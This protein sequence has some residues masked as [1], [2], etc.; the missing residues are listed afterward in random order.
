MKLTGAAASYRKSVGPNNNFTDETDWTP[1]RVTGHLEIAAWPRTGHSEVPMS[2]SDLW[3]GLDPAARAHLETRDYARPG[4]AERLAT[5]GAEAAELAGGPTEALGAVWIPGVEIF[6]RQVWQ[7]RHRGWFAEFSRRDDPNSVLT[8]IGMWPAQWATAL[9][10]PNTAKGFHIHPPHVPTGTAAEAWF[11]RLFLDQ[12]TNY[13]LRPYTLE[14]WDAMFFVH[15]TC[16]MVLVEA[17]LG[18][19]RRTMRFV[20]EGD[21]RPGASNVGVVIPPGVAHAIR[22]A[23]SQDLIMVYGT[24]TQFEAANEGRI[25]SEVELAPLPEP[26]VQFLGK[27]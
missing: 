27:P 1:P 26:W 21:N 22:V 24:S 10:F 20:I 23:G 6:H 3:R 9:M 2:S 5:S 15:G 4:L 19:P 12:A 7:Q 14:Q 13:S 17:R 25:C 16:E 8:R 11:R 18:L